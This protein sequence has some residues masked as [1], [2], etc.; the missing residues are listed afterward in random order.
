M[1]ISQ[2]ESYKLFRFLSREG[3]KQEIYIKQSCC[4]L[5]SS[6]ALKIDWNNTFPTGVK[7]RMIT[8]GSLIQKGIIMY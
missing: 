8:D 1:F 4:T 5:C 3:S 6:T 2:F 7:H